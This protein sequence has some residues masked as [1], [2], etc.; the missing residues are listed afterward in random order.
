MKKRKIQIEVE[1]YLW[2]CPHDHETFQP[3]KTK[4]FY[5]K[6]C[7][8]E[9]KTV[10]CQLNEWYEHEKILDAYGH[11]HSDYKDLQWLENQN[12]WLKSALRKIF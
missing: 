5:C 9:Y 10:D 3:Y 12:K 4:K 1:G 2:V 6:K 7:D 8:E 11:A